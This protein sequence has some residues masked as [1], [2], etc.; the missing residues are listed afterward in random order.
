MNLVKLLRQS[1]SPINNI[2]LN[3]TRGAKRKGE[4][5]EAGVLTEHI[6]NIYKNAEDVAILPDEYYP[7]WVHDLARPQMCLEEF[8]ANSITGTC[9][10]YHLLKSYLNQLIWTP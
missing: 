6:L 3:T 5:K 8:F 9:V 4:K 1:K 7:E 10:Y 2:L